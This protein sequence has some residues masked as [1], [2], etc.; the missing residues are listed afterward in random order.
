MAV[1]RDE[2]GFAALRRWVLE[3]RFIVL[4]AT[5]LVFLILLPFIRMLG[6]EGGRLPRL[7]NT[8]TFLVVLLS[9]VFAVSRYRVGKVISVLLASA[10][11][12][13]GITHALTRSAPITL[14]YY[15]ATMLFLAYVIIAVVAYLFR[16]Q[17]VTID[18]I[19]A[20]LCVYLMIGLLWSVLYST[21]E[22]NVPGS[23]SMPNPGVDRMQFGAG[24]SALPVY[25][26][27][28]T[29]ST[30]GYGDISPRSM[31]ARLLSA[32]EALIGQLFLAVL[33]ARFVGLHI[34]HAQEQKRDED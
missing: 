5:L 20:S 34:A 1:D 4:L 14:S 3:Q 2:R 8:L 32:G 31:P 24:N 22:L 28:V 30:L 33:V 7:L 27:F 6:R 12:A 17:R 23:F 15:L 10:S 18:M 16:P 11:T 13:L 25:Y 19:C 29:L 21:V 26:S 9:A